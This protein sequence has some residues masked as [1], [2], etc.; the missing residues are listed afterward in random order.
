MFQRLMLALLL[1]FVSAVTSRRT[2]SGIPH[3]DD[4]AQIE[5]APAE[6]EVA[7]KVPFPYVNWANL[8]ESIV[9]TDFLNEPNF[10]IDGQPVSEP[11]DGMDDLYVNA[12]PDMTPS[13]EPSTYMK[14]G[15]V[16]R[17]GH[18]F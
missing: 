17:E 1:L 8:T 14:S 12:D 18:G 7:P 13:E 4:L 11:A 2:V 5:V 15:K 9:A 6:L 16:R 3:P 10:S